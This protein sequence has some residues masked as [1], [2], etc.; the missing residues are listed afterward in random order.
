MTVNSSPPGAQILVD[1]ALTGKKT[2]AIVEMPR[3]EHTVSLQLKSFQPSSARFKVHGGEEFEF[4]PTLSVAMPN[5]PAIPQ[6]SIP[7][8]DLSSLR[9]QGMNGRMAA[10]AARAEG[11]MWR[12]WGERVESGELVIMVSTEPPGARILLDGQDTG[13]KSPNVIPLSAA[14][15]HSVQVQ[16]PGF[17]A[18]Q[19]QVDVQPHTPGQL[20]IILHAAGAAESSD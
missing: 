19:R 8:I 14:G 6:V 9:D 1:G 16:L 4:A 15:K 11:E 7:N 12:R 10:H 13:K 3:G 17:H 5:M 2:P 20:Q 18:E